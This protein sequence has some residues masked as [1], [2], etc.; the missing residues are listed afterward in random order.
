MAQAKKTKST[1]TARVVGSNKIEETKPRIRKT[2]TVRS[3]A[4]KSA[5]KAEARATQQ[6][7]RRVR[8]A[9]SAVAKPLRK[10][11]GILSAPFRLRPVKFV[12]NILGRIFWPKYFRNSYSEV[13]Q[14]TWPT[15]RETWKLTFAVI[16]FAVAFGLAAAGTDWVLDKVIRRIVFRA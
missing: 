14:V 3:R 1:S 12:G 6:P 11:A 10:P 13:R 16:V 2:E 7:K 15:R 4:A 8:R 9:A 5:A